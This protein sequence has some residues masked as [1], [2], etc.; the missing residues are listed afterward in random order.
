MS[1]P[2]NSSPNALPP[3]W[4]L[5]G[6]P[7][8][9][10]V[11]F[12]PVV[13]GGGGG[14]VVA[15]QQ[16]VHPEN[17]LP[18]PPQ[19]KNAVAHLLD[20]G[21]DPS[22]AALFAGGIS[23]RV[24][25]LLTGSGAERALALF[26]P[27]PAQLAAAGPS[28]GSPPAAVAAAT[29]AAAAP[30]LSS[31][32]PDVAVMFA[33][34]AGGGV[35]ASA[36]NTSD[37]G[38][39]GVKLFS[40]P[41][42]GGGGAPLGSPGGAAANTNIK[43]AGSG[44]PAPV[45]SSNVS[46]ES[47]PAGGAPLGGGGPGGG[48]PLGG[49]VPLGGASPGG[50]APLGGA[51][52][53]GGAPLGGASPGGGAPL[54]GGVPLGGA[55]PGGGA[56]LAGSGPGGGV[57]LGGGAAGGA[58]LAAALGKGVDPAYAE[59]LQ[60]H[61]NQEQALR[62]IRQ[63]SA[64]DNLRAI[65]TGPLGPGIIKKFRE[66][67][68]IIPPLDPRRRAQTFEERYRVDNYRFHLYRTA[69]KGRFNQDE[70][71]LYRTKWLDYPYPRGGTAD[72]RANTKGATRP[73]Y[74]K[75]P[76]K[77]PS[78]LDDAPGLGDAKFKMVRERFQRA[79]TWFQ[80]K[81]PFEFVRPLGYGGLGLTLQYKYTDIAPVMNLV[82]KIAI[83]GWDDKSLRNEEENTRQVARAAHCIQMIP[84]ERVGMRPKKRSRFR[85]PNHFDSSDEGISSGEESRGEEPKEKPKSRRW[86]LENERQKMQLKL[87]LLSDRKDIWRDLVKRRNKRLQ[88]RAIKRQQEGE[89][90]QAS[91]TDDPLDEEW[92]LDY[93][94]Y[95]L[96]EFAE[97]GDLA[98]FIYKTNEMGE[99]V[100]NRVLWSFWLCLVSACVAME[101]PPRK[102]HP[103]RRDPNPAD[104][105]GLPAMDFVD[106][107]SETRGKRIGPDL[108]EDV[109]DPSRRWAGKRQVHFDIDPK[110]ILIY[111]LD[112]NTKDNEHKLIPRL[113]LADFG[114]AHTIKPNKGNGYYWGRRGEYSLPYFGILSRVP[115]LKNVP[116]MTV[117]NYLSYSKPAGKMS[118]Y[119][120][121]QFG[122]DWDYVPA[123]RVY[124]AEI[125]EQPVAGNYA[126]HTNSLWQ[127]MTGARAPLPPAVAPA[128]DPNDPNAPV[129]YCTL[130]NTW[131]QY[132]YIDADL[133]RTVYRCMMHRP[134][135]RPSLLT[136]MNEAKE[137]IK[138]S[139]PGESDDEISAWVAKLLYNAP[140]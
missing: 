124:G 95:L 27:S 65:L 32:G 58:P 31:L 4:Y 131:Q 137:G 25:N 61:I 21:V 112:P 40:P 60:A 92:E 9:G 104:V 87:Q 19:Q 23:P 128:D 107:N 115:L 126:A 132:A 29:A 62:L 90:S 103:K 122:E 106:L 53:G 63:A 111:G 84:P 11:P 38:G 59:I 43:Q 80:K 54:G 113:K 91:T 14:N 5:S 55:S 94:D 50:G 56:P 109:P 26:P 48:A 96:L 30:L 125:S 1:G 119:T 72:P 7:Q 6:Q 45:Y 129:S 116:I 39:G 41:S 18:P 22:I 78:L 82:L 102:F 93:K 120:P 17:P 134:A 8:A 2:H 64:K 140:S 123:S 97:N 130:I 127:L 135:D 85:Q 68:K 99:K 139:Y 74:Y 67:N 35:A 79:S 57:P 108:Y 28:G 86:R 49:G 3:Y 66:K 117:A 110:N 24:A 16:N 69:G 88:A 73:G 81:G 20:S 76:P 77:P 118:Y 10:M 70:E 98:N 51:S 71:A 52:P 136:L 44:G 13:A 12:N 133:R 33:V 100:P 47:N 46:S 36:D 15:P 101:Y 83:R 42:A 105:E 89:A 114:L 37:N 34:V 138:R 75:R 121:E